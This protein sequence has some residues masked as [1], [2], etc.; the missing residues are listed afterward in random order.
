MM[1]VTITIPDQFIINFESGTVA[2]NPAFWSDKRLLA[3]VEYYQKWEMECLKN[4]ANFA[5][6]RWYA[7]SQLAREAAFT[8]Q[9]MPGTTETDAE[10]AYIEFNSRGAK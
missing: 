6:G 3:C 4:R 2:P 5:D 1:T 9:P 10:K 8:F 7:L